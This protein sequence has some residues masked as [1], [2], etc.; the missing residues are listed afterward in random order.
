MLEHPDLQ[1]IFSDRRA[2][3]VSKD[4]RLRIFHPPEAACRTSSSAT[5][6]GRLC[7]TDVRLEVVGPRNPSREAARGWLQRLVGLATARTTGG[8]LIS[9]PT[10]S[11]QYRRL[12]NCNPSYLDSGLG[13]GITY[14]RVQ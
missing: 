5:L 3:M 7:S 11:Y 2:E 6:S 10:P 9:L 12:L 13:F 8:D 1:H 4:K 14:M